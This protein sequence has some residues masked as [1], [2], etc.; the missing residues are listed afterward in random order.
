MKKSLLTPIFLIILVG[1]AFEVWLSMTLRR[2]I[3]NK[4]GF[5]RKK[6]FYIVMMIVTV[7]LLPGS[8]VFAKWTSVT[9]PDVS[10]GWELS[11][12]YF[13]SPSDGWAVGYDYMNISG[14]LL[15]YSNGT[16]TSVT[17]PGGSGE[18]WLLS[19]H[20]TSSSEGW[21][22]GADNS[23]G[24]GVLLHY[25]N[26][27]WT[28]VTPPDVSSSWELSDV[29]FTSPSEGWAVGG[30][31]SNGS[32]VL[33]H[34]SNGIW[35][36]ITPPDVG[37]NS[38]CE[39]SDVHFTSPSEG[40]A[41]GDKLTEV[42]E[43]LKGVL[44]HYSNGTWTSV[45][46]PGGSGEWWLLSI[47]FTS[48]SEGWAVGGNRSNGRGVLLHYSNGTWTSVTPPDVSSSWELSNVHFTSPSEGWAVGDKY[49]YDYELGVNEPFEGVLLHY[50]NG[51]W[52]SITPPDVSSFWWLNSVHFTSPSEG[53]AVGGDDSNGRGVLFRRSTP[54]SAPTGISA[55]DGTY[56]DKVEVTW[57]AS[58][59]A[60]S[61][62]VYRATSSDTGATKTLL[63]TTTD[64]FFDDTTAVPQKTYYYW[65]KALNAIGSS[66]FSAYDKGYRSDGSP[67]VP[68]NVSA[69]DGIYTD[70]VEVTWTASLRAESYKVYRARSKD[71]GPTK[72]LL[73]TTTDILFNDTTAVPGKIYYYWV[74]ASNTIGT[75]KFSAYDKGYR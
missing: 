72:K 35:T 30:N 75:S 46:P 69:S 15:H 8:I 31:H 49:T 57:S 41:V 23:N 42:T 66:K 52:T 45:T 6:G 65:V 34:Y 29:H 48:S 2:W 63:G 44:L 43:T 68:T 10:G 67:L 20:F 74:K 58:L 28:S 21:A 3:M 55:S 26:D 70:R 40:W 61:Y 9:P 18:W 19:I 56:M 24:S 59:G 32:G 25:S 71:P 12:V 11:G 13:T 22:V 39:L 36:T 47:H 62:K 14:V 60:E 54:P 51:T 73:G 50:S 53:W 1:T 16:W 38:G 4:I 5:A 17:P 64:T 27:T 37:S 7:L 33:L